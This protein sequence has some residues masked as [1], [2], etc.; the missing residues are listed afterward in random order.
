MSADLAERLRELW[1]L[2]GRSLRDLERATRTSNSS[3]SRYFAGKSIPPWSVVVELC[4]VTGHDPRPLRHLWERGR[5]GPHEPAGQQAQPRNFLPSDAT[6]FTGR[7]AEKAALLAALAQARV[8]AVDGMGGVG[9]TALAVHVA[10]QVDCD[11]RL[12]IDLHGFTPGREPVRSEEA[13]RILLTALEVPAGR[14]PDSGEERA[15][16]WR[17]ELAPRRAVV[18][19]DNAADADHVRPLLPGAGESA[20]IVTSRRRLV[21]LDEVSPISLDAM[22]TAEATDLFAA[23]AGADRVGCEPA[24]TAAVVRLCGNLPLTVRVAAARLRHRPTWTVAN[25]AERLRDGDMG[26]PGALEMSLRQLSPDERRMFHLLGAVPGADL[27]VY[28]AAALG[29]LP[30]AEVWARLDE[31]VDTNLIQEPKAGRYRMHDLLRRMALTGGTDRDLALARLVDYYLVCTHTAAVALA[32]GGRS[33]PVRVAHPPAAVP[34]LD[35]SDAALAWL[36]TEVDNILSTFDAVVAAGLDAAVCGLAITFRVYFGRR[37]GIARWKDMLAAAIPAAERLGDRHSQAA[38]RHLHGVAAQWTGDLPEAVADFET[39]RRLTAEAGDVAG[40]NQALRQLANVLAD[41]GQFHRAVDVYREAVAGLAEPQFAQSQA[42]ARAQMCE[43]LLWL[44]RAG[45]VA[46]IA[47]ETLAVARAAGDPHLETLSLRQLGMAALMFG[48]TGQAVE[49]F[50]AGLALSRATGHRLREAGYLTEL[51]VAE[52]E[53]GEM[54]LALAHHREAMDILDEVD[55]PAW[56]LLARNPHGESLLA[57][58]LVAE[59]ERSHRRALELARANGARHIEAQAHRGIAAALAVGEPGSAEGRRHAEAAEAIA[60]EL[61][62]TWPSRGP[63][64]AAHP[65]PPGRHRPGRQGVADVAIA[66]HVAGA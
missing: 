47:R 15:A 26:V 6:G 38:L 46:G 4:R 66:S 45:E 22:S 40:E 51:A 34:A 19:L 61:G 32:H 59:A 39:S 65:G 44:G 52:R 7:G 2:S 62:I 48:D 53:S 57:A 36:D 20:V 18:L 55:E 50:R 24:A 5:R 17:A 11:T 35:D 14:I 25:L 9:K 42:F 29:D 63:A 60:A 49:H 10:H 27:D 31:L 28:V 13:L 21:D 37:G 30:L 1:R 8:V 23:V 58:G 56:E 54:D 64:G 3:L 12:Y 33:D 41:S 43:A 16:L